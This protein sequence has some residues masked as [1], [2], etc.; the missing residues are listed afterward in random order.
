MTTRPRR[1][2]PRDARLRLFPN[3][4]PCNPSLTPRPPPAHPPNFA[5]KLS[6]VPFPFLGPR[7]FLDR[8]PAACDPASLPDLAMTASSSQPPAPAY[9]PPTPVFSQ[10]TDDYVFGADDDDDDE[11]AL[12]APAQQQVDAN[13]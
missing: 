1:S 8:P 12:F 9:N 4:H 5:S 2:Q 6:P 11:P 10:D 7:F 3:G 13:G